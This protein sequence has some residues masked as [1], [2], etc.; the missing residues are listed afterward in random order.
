MT[1]VIF[2][3]KVS[4]SISVTHMSECATF[5]SLF[6]CTCVSILLQVLSLIHICFRFCGI[7]TDNLFI[8]SIGNRLISRKLNKLVKLNV[9][10][11][12]LSRKGSCVCICDVCVGVL[13]SVY[14]VSVSF[15]I[16]MPFIPGKT[17]VLFVPRDRDRQP[18]RVVTLIRSHY[19]TTASVSRERNQYASA[20]HIF[21]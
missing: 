21:V 14:T 6:S 16:S 9:T 3:H 13:A 1:V 17:K 19:R 8:S 15:Y 18:D 5:G 7:V 10:N 2:M 20:P 11:R 12:K 4:K